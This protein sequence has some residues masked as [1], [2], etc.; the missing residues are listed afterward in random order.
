MIENNKNSLKKKQK[1][2]VI[3]QE[4]KFKAELLS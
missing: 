1:Q 3:Q 2:L 4:N